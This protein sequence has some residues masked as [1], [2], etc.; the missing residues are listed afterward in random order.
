[1]ALQVMS[2]GRGRSERVT[3]PVKSLTGFTMIV[4]MAGVV[5]S[6]GTVLGRVAPIVKSATGVELNA[7]RDD[8]CDSGLCGDNSGCTVKLNTNSSKRIL[9]LNGRQ[10][11]EFPNGLDKL[12]PRD[13]NN[14]ALRI[15]Q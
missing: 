8:A 11:G 15:F 3:V 5:P 4:E 1:M 12:R 7:Q 14:L 6:A 2:A 13:F 9:L 10:I